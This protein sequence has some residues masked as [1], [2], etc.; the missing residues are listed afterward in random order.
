MLAYQL[1]YDHTL[2][3]SQAICKAAEWHVCSCDAYLYVITLETL[4]IQN[5]ANC[6]RPAMK[7]PY[8]RSR[9]LST[10]L[11]YATY[12]VNMEQNSVIGIPLVSLSRTKLYESCKG[13]E[14]PYC[15][16]H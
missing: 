16:V 1:F 8:E 5:Q 14:S 13:R 10:Y 9:Y 11:C 3:R 4:L 12:A 15:G 6:D 2:T 7:E